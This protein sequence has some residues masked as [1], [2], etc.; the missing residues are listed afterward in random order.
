[1]RI[2]L[3]TS[4]LTNPLAKVFTDM[5]LNQRLVS[6]EYIRRHLEYGLEEYATKGHIDIPMRAMSVMIK[7]PTDVYYEKHLAE[8]RKENPG[9]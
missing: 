7:E 2:Y 3:V 4:S 6:Y 5:E 8:I 1:M 9:E